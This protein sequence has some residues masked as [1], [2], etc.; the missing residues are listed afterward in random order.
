MPFLEMNLKKSNHILY[1]IVCYI[2]CKKWERK[3]K[4]KHNKRTAETLC[5]IERRIKKETSLK[6]V[7]V[8]L[9]SQLVVFFLRKENKKTYRTKTTKQKWLNYLWNMSAYCIVCVMQSSK[10]RHRWCCRCRISKSEVQRIQNSIRI[11]V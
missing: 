5:L 8:I 6:S 1:H 2:S 7:W 11:F 10:D 9:E 4:K 3:N